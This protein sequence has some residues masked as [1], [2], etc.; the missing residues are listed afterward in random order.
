MI[1]VDP[2]ILLHDHPEKPYGVFFCYG[3]RMNG[4]HCRFRDIARGGLRVVP[5]EGNERFGQESMRHFDEVYGLAFAQQ[6]KNKDIPEGGSKAVCMVNVS[7]R[8]PDSRDF[9]VRKAVRSFTAGLLDLI[10]PDPEVKKNQ[11]DYWGQDELLYL[12]PDENI[13]PE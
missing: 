6:L 10:T 2:D 7:D 13:I 12:G 9:L 3:R 1:R 5:V 11:V 8:M 4:F